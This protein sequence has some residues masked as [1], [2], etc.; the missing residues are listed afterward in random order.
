[1]VLGIL[2]SSLFYGAEVFAHQLTEEAAKAWR[3]QMA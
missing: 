2:Y 3:A 1:M